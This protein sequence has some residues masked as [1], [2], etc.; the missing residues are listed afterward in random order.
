MQKLWRTLHQRNGNYPGQKIENTGNRQYQLSVKTRSKMVTALTGKS[1]TKNYWLEKYHGAHSLVMSKTWDMSP[2]ISTTGWYEMKAPKLSDSGH[3]VKIIL[4]HVTHFAPAKL[5]I[6]IKSK[7]HIG[8]LMKDQF[9]SDSPVR[10]INK[11]LIWS[12]LIS[13][14]FFDKVV[15]FHE[16]CSTLITN[17]APFSF[18]CYGDRTIP[19][20]RERARNEL[21]WWLGSSQQCASHVLYLFWHLGRTPSIPL[22]RSVS[23]YRRPIG[24]WC[25]KESPSRGLEPLPNL[26]MWVT[27]GPKWVWKGMFISLKLLSASKGGVACVCALVECVYVRTCFIMQQGCMSGR[28]TPTAGGAQL[29]DRHRGGSQPIITPPFCNNIVWWTTTSSLIT[30][31]QSPSFRAQCVWAYCKCNW[32][33]G[34]APGLHCTVSGPQCKCFCFSFESGLRW[35]LSQMGNIGYSPCTSALVS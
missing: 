25:I 22:S 20:S 4:S 35:G 23:Y 30:P 13:E 16:T 7:L 33:P 5:L 32:R 24:L 26:E 8:F 31:D 9:L 19:D 2:Q 17:L 3:W 6:I 12:S 14:Y 18:C 10:H 29:C 21:T 11:T 34:K 28:P 15:I 1:L 27:Y